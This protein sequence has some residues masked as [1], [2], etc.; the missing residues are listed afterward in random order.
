MFYKLKLQISNPKFFYATTILILIIRNGL[1][2]IGPEWVNWLRSASQTFPVADSYL[3]YSWIYIFLM[4]LAHYPPTIAWW[5]LNSFFAL[6]Y[7]V[8]FYYL[9][10]KK[11]KNLTLVAL[12]ILTIFPV[13]FEPLLYIGHY[14]QLTIFAAML[15]AF[16]NSK[17]L[18]F[19]SAILASGSNP[20]QAF[21]TSLLI[22]LLFFAT[23]ISKHKIISSIYL[24]TSLATFLV[25]KVFT[26][27]PTNGDRLAIDII[28]FP[29]VLMNSLGKLHLIA[30]SFLGVGTVYLATINYLPISSRSKILIFLSVFFLP[31]LL[32][33]AIL[34]RSRIAIAVGALP[35]FLAFEYIFDSIYIN[36]LTIKKIKFVYIV[37][38]LVPLINIDS[39]GY[40]RLPYE[41]LIERI[42]QLV[43]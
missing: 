32:S 35:L 36:E 37:S 19:I 3:S 9:I 41:K 34:D 26:G 11:Y 24:T 38:L 6:F 4:K 29:L 28:Q 18:I 39:D 8:I 2:P 17:W 40:L 7:L 13:F 30:F 31:V 43:S 15:A 23:K 1:H 14:D 33:F 25:L 27:T 10:Y 12:S 21:V 16:T 22:G 42:S 5:I 20:E